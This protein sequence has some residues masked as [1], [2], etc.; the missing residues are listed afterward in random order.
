MKDGIDDDMV[1]TGVLITPVMVEIDEILDV[2]M[3]ANILYV[4]HRHNYVFS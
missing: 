4:L 1:E 3:G 2:V